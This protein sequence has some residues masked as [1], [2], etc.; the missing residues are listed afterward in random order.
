MMKSL[1]TNAQAVLHALFKD[2]QAAYPT[3][4]GL[5][6]D[7]ERLLALVKNRGLASLMLDLPALDSLLTRGL[8]TGRLVLEGPLTHAVSKRVRVPRLFSGLWL[9]IFDSE[10]SLRNVV[11]VTAIFMLRN[12][13]SFFK[14]I[15][16]PCSDSRR[17]AAVKEYYDV[18]RS[19]RSPTLLWG[20]SE[21]DCF[22]SLRTVHFR[23]GLDDPHACFW[24]DN[25]RTR[26]TI[27]FLA[28]RLQRICDSV[29][30]ELGYYDPYEFTNSVGKSSTT[31]RFL[32]HGRGSVSDL[33][34]HADKYA[35]PNWSERLQRVF[36]NDAFG[37][38]RFDNTLEYHSWK[39]SQ[40]SKLIAVPKNAKTPRLIASEPTAHQWC[41]QI[42]L[43]W[44]I[45]RMQGTRL[46]WF[47]DLSNQKLSQNMVLQQSMPMPGKEK[48]RCATVD[49][50]S[51]SD[52]LSCWA[53][54]RAFRRNPVLLDSLQASRTPSLV[55]GV[56]A[57][58]PIFLKKFAT[59]G[60]GV[61]FPIQSIFFLCCVL[62]SLGCNTLKD[63][64]RWKG[65]V[66][67]YGDDII[68]PAHGYE[69]LRLL[70]QFLELKVNE[71]K[72]FVHGDFRESCGMDAFRGYN[73]TPIKPKTLVHRGP[74]SERAL[75]D[76]S[77]NLWLAG[78]WHTATWFES[79]INRHHYPIVR[80]GLGGVGRTSFCGSKVDHLKSRWNPQLHRMEVR[81]RVMTDTAPKKPYDST[82][83]IFQYFAENPS[84]L[85]TWSSGSQ[86]EEKTVTR[87]RWVDTSELAAP[88]PLC[89]IRRERSLS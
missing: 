63:A 52:R 10:G 32:S 31:G 8:E 16:V 27:E 7:R 85:T 15:E 14:S 72:S 28:H 88:V 68:I 18:E 29:A 69:N 34:R 1:V 38:Y 51:A 58:K 20:D 30:G 2:V 76:T 44:L 84:P 24:E 42:T 46:R 13:C 39:E 62:A 64:R 21:F 79:T 57:E 45:Q 48:E 67:V 47:L 78:L 5:D 66:R 86:L 43:R 75:L 65:K 53:I 23:D 61:T 36:P 37:H 73:V 70:L 25:P 9:R 80:L 77:N 33:S 82:S 81:C 6:L 56:T 26:S 11:D 59:Q 19:L 87:L 40:T 35:L 22:G 71:D 55:D 74:K 41:Q 12:L 3:M 17:E 50:S 54:E 49:L 60:T 89:Y 4:S 83:G